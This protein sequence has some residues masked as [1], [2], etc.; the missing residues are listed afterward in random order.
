MTPHFSLTSHFTWI[1]VL[2]RT[3]FLHLTHLF[4]EGLSAG[5]LR[6]SKPWLQLC[7]KISD[8]RTSHRRDAQGRRLNLL[9]L[10]HNI[11]YYILHQSIVS[12][13]KDNNRLF[14][15]TCNLVWKVSPPP[16][17]P[18]VLNPHGVFQSWSEGMIKRSKY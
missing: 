15:G 2:L 11:L 13:I 10:C 3:H 4:C 6:G 17:L 1:H 16:P 7:K 8:N 14:W 12:M 18:H 5:S 9:L